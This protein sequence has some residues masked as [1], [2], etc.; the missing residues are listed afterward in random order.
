MTEVMEVRGYTA[1]GV[2]HGFDL[3]YTVASDQPGNVLP[4]GDQ[5]A[6]ATDGQNFLAANDDANGL[7]GT[8]FDAS[9]ATVTNV[10]LAPGAGSAFELAAF[11][12]VNY[13]VVF[14]PYSS[15]TSGEVTSC[16]AQRISPAGA[17]VDQTP[18]NLV[19]VSGPLGSIGSSGIAFGKT[20]GLLAYT[21]FN[22]TTNQHE[23][24]GVLISPDG[25]VTSPFAI[26]TDNSTHLY[27]AV[28]FDGT[29]FFVAWQQ[30]ATSG[31]TAGSVYGVRVSA[32]GQVIDAEPIAIATAP[33]GEYNP[34]VAFDGGNYLIVWLSRR[35][36]SGNPTNFHPEVFGA[37]VS[38][39]GVLLDGP[40]E[41][42]GF[43]ISQGGTLDRSPAHVV[44]NGNEYLVTWTLL[45]YVSGGVPGVQAVRVST[46]GTLPSGA[47]QMI[48]VSGPPGNSIETFE[49]PAIAVGARRGAIIWRDIQNNVTLMG[50]TFST[51]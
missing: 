4:V 17:L 39:G 41:S 28:A 46:D 32:S 5:P 1:S 31:A 50:S 16:L 37:R 21:A 49:S 24:H 20:N 36:Q 15:V 13:W 29:N 40:P 47:N 51:F 14:S 22:L 12:G 6:L 8:L 33:S 27:P 48:P 34:S 44:F 9:G 38:A 23:L 7:V 45:G 3:P 2:S 35:N 30:L 10:R 11:D 18:I 19:T 43:T 26:A 42:G 25:T